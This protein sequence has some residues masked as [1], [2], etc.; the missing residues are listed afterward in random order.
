M[1][2]KKEKNF[3][4]LFENEKAISKEEL[5]AARGGA[6]C[7]NVFIGSPVN[8]VCDEFYI[9]VGAVERPTSHF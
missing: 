6:I 8:Y 3:E 4:L 2:N 1:K 9:G 5:I 7:G